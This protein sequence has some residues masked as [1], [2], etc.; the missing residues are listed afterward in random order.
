MNS[1]QYIVCCDAMPLKQ[2]PI[3][4]YIERNRKTRGV[5][6]LRYSSSLQYISDFRWTCTTELSS[7]EVDQLQVAPHFTSLQIDS[8]LSSIYFGQEFNPV[9]P[10][11][12]Q[13]R[14]NVL[15]RVESGDWLPSKRLMM[16][17]LVSVESRSGMCKTGAKLFVLYML[18]FS[19]G[20]RIWKFHT[21]AKMRC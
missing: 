13:F 18:I 1:R 10:C 17:R 16:H 3:F 14:L 8:M 7:N 2:F 9:W 11:R 19:F 6:P 4:G 21:R 12:S 15:R 20:W 5:E